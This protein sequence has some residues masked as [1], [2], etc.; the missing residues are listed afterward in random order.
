M[1]ILLIGH[2]PKK[3]SGSAILFKQLVNNIKSR[4]DIEIKVVNTNRLSPFKKNFVVKFVIALFVISEVLYSLSKA[5]VVSF[6]ASRPAMISFAPVLYFVTRIYKKPL[7][8]RL[9]GG[10]FETEYEELSPSKR[11]LFNKTI[12]GAELI[13][14]ETKFLL[15][16]FEKLAP[17]NI[18]WYS[19]STKIIDL[20]IKRD[21]EKQNCGRFIFLGLVKEKK[22]V[23]IILDSVKYLLP[24]ISIDLFGPLE[25]KFTQEYIQSKGEKVC[26]YRGVL[27]QDQVQEKLFDYDTLILPTFYEGEGYPGVIIEAYSH[28][29]PVIATNWRSIPEIVTPETGILISPHSPKELAMA[30]N[31]I[32]KNNSL[33][34]RL[35]EGAISKRMEFSD[36]YWTEQF[37]EWC[38]QLSGHSVY[39][40]R[41]E[42]SELADGA[43]NRK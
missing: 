29:L 31:K 22:G 3:P 39:P 8:L 1:N 42:V 15:K 5:H 19:N 27:T 36:I 10:A 30:M 43:T 9:F 4:N 17:K 23:D 34:K 20:S 28:G 26:C 14:V 18:K 33:Y 37:I 2:L 38:I 35:Q 21:I 11:R 6:H 25:G 12:L 16:Y 40:M 7:F 13:T 32:H 41:Y 24:G